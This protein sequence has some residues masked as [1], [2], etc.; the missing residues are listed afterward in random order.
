MPKI[1]KDKNGTQYT[2]HLTLGKCREI[3]GKLDIDA[4]NPRDIPELIDS[5]ATRLAFV[6]Y[7]VEDQAIEKGVTLEKW[8]ENLMGE[9]VADDCGDA[10]LSELADFSHAFGQAGAAL[11]IRKAL[12]GLK[13][14]R[15]MTQ[16]AEF[17]KQIDR[18]MKAAT[19][20]ATS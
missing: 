10:M 12:E 4:T 18:A 2:I 16:S 5:L 6:W 14:M 9:G 3:R 11:T 8:E 1:F 7:C 19:A 17:E 13:A 15:T 20:G